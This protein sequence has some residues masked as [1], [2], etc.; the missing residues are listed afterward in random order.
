VVAVSHG[1]PIRLALAHYAGVHLDHFQRLEVAPASV[2]AVAVGDHAPTVLRVN[3]TGD[4]AHLFP[5]R[6]RRR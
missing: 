4:L 1:D 5:R 2:S 6:T 3:D